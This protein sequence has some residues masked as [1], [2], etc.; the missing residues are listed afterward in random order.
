ME[1]LRDKHELA[2]SPQLGSLLHS[3]RKKQ[4]LQDAARLAAREVAAAEDTVLLPELRAR[5]RVL[6][7]L[8]CETAPAC[9][10]SETARCRRLDGMRLPVLHVGTHRSAKQ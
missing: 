2:S 3:L 5:R 1:R 10:A 4:S 9:L 7:R 6:Q 8:G